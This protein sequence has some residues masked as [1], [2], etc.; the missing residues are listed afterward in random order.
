MRQCQDWI[1]SYKCPLE[2]CSCLARDHKLRNFNRAA[3]VSRA[4]PEG[5]PDVWHEE[6]L[7]TN[8]EAFQASTSGGRS[9]IS[10]GDIAD[11]CVLDLDPLS[12]D[13]RALRKIQVHATLLEG[14]F[15]YNRLEE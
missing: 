11:L 15:T 12:C 6:Q 8:L 4:W 13:G 3:A 7:I 10:E 5:S 14:R 9:R 1:P 2:R